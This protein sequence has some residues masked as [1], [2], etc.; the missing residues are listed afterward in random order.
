MVEALK[1]ETLAERTETTGHT[2][3]ENIEEQC[4]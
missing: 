4:I 2:D 3:T 1:V